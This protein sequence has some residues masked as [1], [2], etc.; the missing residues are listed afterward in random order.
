MENLAILTDSYKATHWKQYPPGTETVYSYLEARGGE[1]DS[2]V[3]FG[4]QYFLKKYFSIPV[5]IKDVNEADKFWTS[6][7]GPGMFNKE[8]WEYIVSA[9]GG[10]LPIKICAVPEGT[11]NPVKT[12]LMTIENTDPK[13]FWL[14]NWLETL[15]MQIWYPSTV[16][17][18]SLFMKK[19]LHESLKRTGTPELIDFKLHD[20]GFRGVSSLESA[21]IGAAAHLVNFLG[22]DTPHGLLLLSQ[23]YDAEMA[24]FSIPASE[25]ST[26]TSWGKNRE[27]QA[28]A[29]MLEQYP[30]GLVACV[31]DSYDIYNACEN[32]WGTQLKDK[33]LERDGTLVI[34]PDSGDPEIV[35]PTILDILYKK[36]GGTVNTKGFK[37]LNDKVRL[38]QGDGI[39]IVTLQDILY[40][41]E[42]EGWSTDNIAFGSGGGLLQKVNR[43]T[44]KYAIK[45]SAVQINGVWNDVYKD[46]ITDPGKK[47]KMGR[48]A[49]PP[50]F[51][52][53]N[54]VRTQTLADIRENTKGLFV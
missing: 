6:H 13:C 53:G 19:L 37:V 29:N 48:F 30:S 15:L 43:D 38:I 52:N 28:C 45:C 27:L 39:D 21:G 50:V 9:H 49:L 24:G 31:S 36:F 23:Y 2:T 7:L 34:R 3:F 33:I 42:D 35:L 11:L 1:F 46:P 51:I 40:A 18:N 14:T 22:T 5:T 44:C 25:H 41:L 26:I 8:G 17:T 32:L 47:S 12:V 4:L 54:I 16:C 20:F 10:R